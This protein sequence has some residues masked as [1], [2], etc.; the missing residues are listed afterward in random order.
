MRFTKLAKKKTKKKASETYISHKRITP[1][2]KLH[3]FEKQMGI[4]KG[5]WKQ[6][7]KAGFP[8]AKK[9]KRSN[10]IK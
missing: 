10:E 8:V 6:N 1:K 7:V 9:R 4:P 3:E 2:R 5:T